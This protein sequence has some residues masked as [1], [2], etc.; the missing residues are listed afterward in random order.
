MLIKILDFQFRKLNEGFQLDVYSRDNSQPL[1]TVNLKFPRSFLNGTELKQLDFDTKD[2][3]GRVER[4]REFGRKLYQ[5]IF[6][7]EVEHV[8][9]EHK[10]NRE[11]E[12]LV[13]CIRIADNA[14]ELEAIAWETLYDEEESGF[15]AAGTRTT[16]TSLPLD[17]QPQ[18]A[19]DA[20]PL[21]LKM[22]AL[23]S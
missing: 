8:W 4:L 11:Y 12:L 9:E 14:N 19:L 6:T 1:A 22:L 21:P 18:A 17:I 10:Q 23:V 5:Q 2:P 16:I 13:L 15:I 20:V 7:P 3:A